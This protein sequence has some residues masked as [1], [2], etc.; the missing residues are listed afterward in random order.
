MGCENDVVW[1][2]DTVWNSIAFLP[3]VTYAY[4]ILSAFCLPSVWTPDRSG[5]GASGGGDTKQGLFEYFS[6]EIRYPA[7]ADYVTE[8]NE[9]ET[10]KRQIERE[11]GKE[12]QRSK[13]TEEEGR[14]ITGNWNRSLNSTLL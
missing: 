8:R 13:G 14:E 11:R 10:R 7:S 1:W 4:A 2:H 3:S 6:T 5:S 9:R 12:M